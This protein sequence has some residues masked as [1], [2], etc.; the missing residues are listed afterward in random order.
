MTTTD[1]NAEIR[2]HRAAAAEYRSQ[3]AEASQQGDWRKA[4]DLRGKADASEHAVDLCV[5]RRD[6][7]PD[8]PLS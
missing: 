7:Y 8:A 3:A 4:R 5:K 2:K 1:W 6:H